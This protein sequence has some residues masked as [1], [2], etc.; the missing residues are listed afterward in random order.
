MVKMRFALCAALA[1]F[2]MP[3][4]GAMAAPL[5]PDGPRCASG[6]GPAVLV[7]VTGLKNRAGK[8]RVRSFNG[9]IPSHWFNKKHAM[10]RI[11]VDIPSAGPVELCVAVPK[12]G[13]YVLDLRHD[14]NG[15]GD[16]DRADGVG[17]TGNPTISMF[18]VMFGK[19]PPAAKVVMQVGAGVTT[20]TLTMKYLQGGSFKSVQTG[21]R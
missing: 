21:G 3:V 4:S 7:K 5:G 11:E 20:V 6:D 18:D 17:A 13:P 16:S 10:K 8:V 14:T 12:A 9:A 19:K 2:L 15:N 1:A